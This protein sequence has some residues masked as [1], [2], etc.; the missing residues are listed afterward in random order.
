MNEIQFRLIKGESDKDIMRTVLLSERNYYKY[1][2]K[3]A[4]KLEEI[5]KEKSDT[6]IWLEVQTLRIACLNYI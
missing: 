4:S 3:L 2:K 6:D 5:Q 1:K